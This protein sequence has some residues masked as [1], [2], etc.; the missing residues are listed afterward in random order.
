MRVLRILQ[1][2]PLPLGMVGYALYDAG[3]V[4]ARLNHL[5]IP[6]QFARQMLTIHNQDLFLASNANRDHLVSIVYLS[7]AGALKCSI[8]ESEIDIP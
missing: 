2:V 7:T 5:A 6:F 1:A 3:V 4:D 8:Q